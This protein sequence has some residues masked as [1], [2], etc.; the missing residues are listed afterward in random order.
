MRV[1]NVYELINSLNTSSD[2]IKENSNRIL[3][4]IYHDVYGVIENIFIQAK[5][6]HN[7][8]SCNYDN[9]TRGASNLKNSLPAFLDGNNSIVTF[10]NEMVND[11]NQEFIDL[12]FK[13]IDPFLT[14]I[15][16][17]YYQVSDYNSI[18][19][20]FNL[21]CMLKAYHEHK[22]NFDLFSKF[23]DDCSC[24]INANLLSDSSYS[25]LDLGNKKSL[26]DCII[27]SKGYN[28]IDQVNKL[29]K[30]VLKDMG[31]SYGYSSDDVSKKVKIL[32]AVESVYVDYQCLMDE[33]P[34]Y[35][36]MDFNVIANDTFRYSSG[37]SSRRIYYSKI[38]LFGERYE[39]I[40][41]NLTKYID[42]ESFAEEVFKCIT[43]LDYHM[44]EYLN[45][46]DN[47]KGLDSFVKCMNVIFDS[48]TYY[49]VSNKISALKDASS[50]FKEGKREEALNICS[51][52]NDI[53][54]KL[55]IDN[56][57]MVYG[58]NSMNKVNKPLSITKR[59]MEIYSRKYPNIEISRIFNHIFSNHSYYLYNFTDKVNNMIKKEVDLL[60]EKERQRKE[61]EDRL[62]REREM[63]EK[64]SFSNTS[65]VV[66]D[67]LQEEKGIN[68]RTNDI[69]PALLQF[70][71]QPPKTD[72]SSD[73]N[74]PFQKFKS[75][76]G[77]RP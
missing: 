62:R 4:Y 49:E 61:T 38:L 42:N 74:K 12:F 21:Y 34:D 73:D 16:N 37:Y 22:D 2:N 48:D 45:E 72:I 30:D 43:S 64:V 26:I 35:K 18:N 10:L 19:F 11:N 17:K 60:E 68:D 1:E 39:F 27:S 33:N 50:K 9:A 65:T 47:F 31:R 76:F 55:V 59:M 51:S 58:S 71:E 56:K 7:E 63:D 15:E 28:D 54:H 25:N 29:L 75:I 36:L 57:Y 70:V 52:L 40:E 5:Q 3:R 44:F 20:T 8:G 32:K 77:K 53:K 14:I 69:D 66:E 46:Q 6:K 24:F 41:R 67:V 23:L 13:K